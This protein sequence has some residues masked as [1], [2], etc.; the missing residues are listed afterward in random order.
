VYETAGE[1]SVRLTLI[2]ATGDESSDT[3]PVSVGERVDAEISWTPE[4]PAVGEPVTFNITDT[5]GD[6]TSY[7]WIF[8]RRDEDPRQTTITGPE[9]V[10]HTFETAGTIT[11]T[12]QLEP[13][14]GF[15]MNDVSARITVVDN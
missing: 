4:E 11:V 3:L 8:P 6:V 13:G 2:G 9:P 15:I 5:Q 10:T 12:L 7:T 14:D 1:Y